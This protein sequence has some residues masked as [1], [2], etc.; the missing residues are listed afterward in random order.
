MPSDSL[1]VS[2]WIKS[3]MLVLPHVS[4]GVGA[5]SGEQPINSSSCIVSQVGSPLLAVMFSLY[6]KYALLLETSKSFHV[7]NVNNTPTR[8]SRVSNV[9]KLSL[10]AS[11]VQSFGSFVRSAAQWNGYIRYFVKTFLTENACPIF[12]VVNGVQ[13]SPIFV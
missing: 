2:D 12:P 5:E 4:V 13:F 9:A 7:A 6:C 3:S 1:D 10:D 11:S 8:L